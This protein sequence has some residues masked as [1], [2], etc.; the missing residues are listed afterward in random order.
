MYEIGER[1][2]GRC[3]TGSGGG[4]WS[5]R[6]V[7]ASMAIMMMVGHSSS[8]AIDIDEEQKTGRPSITLPIR[9]PQPLSRVPPL[10]SRSASRNAGIAVQTPPRP[11]STTYG[12]PKN[13]WQRFEPARSR[14]PCPGS[15]AQ[16]I[17][18]NAAHPPLVKAVI[19]R[20]GSN[21]RGRPDRVLV[22]C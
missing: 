3:I 18:Y 14:S 13:S 16:P 2:D 10:P 4:R 19:G 22:G 17:L 21:L 1:R 20:A 9:N 15:T 5:V 7:Q 11:P 12:P 6:R 8:L